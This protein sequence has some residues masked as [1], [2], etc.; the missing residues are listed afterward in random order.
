MS[1]LVGVDADHADN[2]DEDDL[3]AIFFARFSMLIFF[4]SVDADHHHDD[5]RGDLL[6][7]IDLEAVLV[8]TKEHS[9][10]P[11]EYQLHEGQ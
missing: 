8:A 11:G 5:C 10:D 9:V 2:N 7:D 1:I 4:A 6:E 3:F